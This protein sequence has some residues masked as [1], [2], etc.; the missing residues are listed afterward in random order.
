[1]GKFILQE[2]G[3]SFRYKVLHSN[4]ETFCKGYVKDVLFGKFELQANNKLINHIN[5]TNINS[6]ACDNA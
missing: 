2:S 5:H 1:M 4:V 6:H 3:I